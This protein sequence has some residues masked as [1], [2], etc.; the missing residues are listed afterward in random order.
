MSLLLPLVIHVPQALN[1][2][3]LFP[4]S[5]RD[6]FDLVS[7]TFTRVHVRGIW[8]LQDVL[9]DCSLTIFFFF[10]LFQ[11]NPLANSK[12][13]FLSLSHTRTHAHAHALDVRVVRNP[14]KRETNV[15][16]FDS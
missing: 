5:T 3:S 12:Q 7:S 9:N 1:S 16:K 4:A 13:R 10:S 2:I 15:P 14:A 11:V 8:H 6:I